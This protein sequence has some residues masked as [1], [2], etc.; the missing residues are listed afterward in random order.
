MTFA[1]LLPKMSHRQ[2]RV[3]MDDT[4]PAPPEF[5]GYRASAASVD[6]DYFDVLNAPI[7]SG[8]GF[9][10]D[11]FEA[12][13]RV[14]VVN[15]T[16]VHEVLGDRN[17]IGR[18]VR[19]QNPESPA[20]ERSPVE[21]PDPWYEIVGV[22]SD[23]G[24]THGGDPTITGAGFYHPLAPGA[25]DPVYMAVH[26]RGGTD[27]FAERLR[28]VAAEVDP[29]LLLEE[30]M[31]L[32]QIQQGELRFLASWFRIT[33]LVSALAL[34]LSLA[35]IYSVMSFTV[36]R[37]TREIAC[38]VGMRL[39]TCRRD[40]PIEAAGTGRNRCRRGRLPGGR[41]RI[42]R[43]GDRTVAKGSGAG[44]SLRGIHDGRLHAG[45]HRAHAAR[46]PCR[47]DRGA[48]G[49]IIGTGTY[50]PTF[51][52]TTQNGLTREWPRNIVWQ[53][54]LSLRDRMSTKSQGGDDEWTHSP[55]S[56][57]FN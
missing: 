10:S 11:D 19:Y 37:R 18:R 17:A 31:P 41:P 28:T 3:L 43:L 24:M 33:I 27:S 35:G 4:G 23:L 5:F 53:I 34:L 48:A 39:A 16:F 9:R 46:T 30:L 49:R 44:C 21:E 57:T 54:N 29:T 2:F 7:L 42:R 13:Q 51:S 14:V 40:D 20:D 47:T 25:A 32:D 36:S 52:L 55:P 1:D 26:V 50:V 12:V 6:I 8:R 45:M 56:R 15:Q 38:R 22:V